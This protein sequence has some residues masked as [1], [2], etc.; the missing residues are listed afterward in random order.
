MNGRT[1]NISMIKTRKHDIKIVNSFI[2]G[3]AS[4]SVSSKYQLPCH[5]SIIPLR[6]QPE[7][8]QQHAT[9]RTEFVH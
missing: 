2:Q 7:D 6:L 9:P 4:I 8:S 5:V 3:K 1:E